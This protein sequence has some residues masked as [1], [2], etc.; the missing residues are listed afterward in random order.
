MYLF[1]EVD[2]Y[3]K[4]KVAEIKYPYLEEQLKNREITQEGYETKKNN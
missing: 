1:F 3:F 4:V 2:H